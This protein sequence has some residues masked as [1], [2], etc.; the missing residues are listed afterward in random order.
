MSWIPAL[1]GWVAEEE[2]RGHANPAGHTVGDALP[3]GQYDP[4]RDH[5]SGKASMTCWNENHIS[6]QGRKR[7]NEMVPKINT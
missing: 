6:I 3:M 7:M 5:R 4:E 2:P 1:H